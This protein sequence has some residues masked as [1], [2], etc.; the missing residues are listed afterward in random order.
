MKV[1][2]F[3]LSVIILLTSAASASQSFPECSSDICTRVVHNKDLE[4]LSI[5]VWNNKGQLIHSNQFDL[6]RDAKLIYTSSENSGR[7]LAGGNYYSTSDSGAP[8]APCTSGACSTSVTSS[9]ETATEIVTVIVTYT[10]HNG[11]LVGVNTTSYVSPKVAE[12]DP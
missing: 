10:Y 11:Q 9:Y 7:G 12:I 3:I 5:L 1:K 2:L 4:K 8:P 6:D